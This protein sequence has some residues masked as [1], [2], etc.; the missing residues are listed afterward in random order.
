MK[1]AEGQRYVGAVEAAVKILRRLAE[2]DHP[3]GAAAIARAT[4]LNVSTTFN[5]LKTLVKEGLAVFDETAKT[6]RTGM[7]I[8]ELAAPAL[9]RN[10]QDLMRPLVQQIA[11]AHRVLVAIW[12]VTP[13]RQIVLLDTAASASAMTANI[14]RHTRY[15]ELLGATGYC[16]AA[17]RDYAPD[18]LEA[19]FKELSWQAPPSFDDYMADVEHARQHGYAI[20]WGR[21]IKGV[22]LAGAIACDAAGVP[23]IA[24]SAVI[25][26]EQKTVEEFDA[27][28]RDLRDAARQIET[29]LV[30]SQIEPPDDM[31][32]DPS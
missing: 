5:I 7:G 6:Y 12:Y 9:S 16:I 28:A 21:V 15:P 17:A 2:T 19:R 13:D 1:Q 32:P 27:A 23:Q 8:L 31:G 10:P 20:D 18:V 14:Q 11:D 25:I 26:S 3:E 24:L 29:N 22:A 4:G 30:R